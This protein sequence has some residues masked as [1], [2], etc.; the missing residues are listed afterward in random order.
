MDFQ[1]H[2]SVPAPYWVGRG[3]HHRLPDSGRFKR[4]FSCD[5]GVFSCCVLTKWSWS[6]SVY[7]IRCPNYPHQFVDFI[8]QVPAVLLNI[9][10]L[11]LTSHM[12]SVPERVRWAEGG[13][14]RIFPQGLPSRD[15]AQKFHNVS[16]RWGW[17]CRFQAGNGKKTTSSPEDLWPQWQLK[18]FTI[19][20]ARATWCDYANRW[21]SPVLRRISNPPLALCA[22]CSCRLSGRF[23]AGPVGF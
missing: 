21:M 22:G 16:Y 17:F 19:W 18:Q 7:S 11:L 5:D 3:K 15:S 20:G 6:V 10:L 1:N 13:E 23:K 2:A 4:I 12:T 8:F 14:D 9:F